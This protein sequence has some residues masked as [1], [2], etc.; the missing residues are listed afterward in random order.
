MR[1]AVLGATGHIGT[2]LVPRLVQRG[3][4]VIGISRGIRAPYRDSPEWA[5]VR[6][7]VLDRDALERAGSFGTTIAA[8]ASDAVID[9]ISFTVDSTAQVV[10]AL[11]DRVGQFLHCGTLWVHGVPFS[12]PYDE[13]APRKP[14]GEYGVRKAAIE[15]FL[16]EEATRGFPAT[17]LHPGH[18]TGPGWH[19]INPA[20]HL[21][22]RVFDR[23]ASGDVVT[24]PNDGSATLQHVHADDVAEAFALAVDHAPDSIGESFHIAACEP[25]SMR[26]YAEQAAQWFGRNAN[27]AFLP[28]EEFR[29]TLTPREAALT[30]DHMAH[31][32]HASIDKARRVL[33]FEPRFTAVEA[34]KDAVT[35]SR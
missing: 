4:D 11:R 6:Q 14:F 12:R 15:K 35:G 24:L 30:Y 16:L 33:G 29:T 23:L 21:D 8:L 20:G 5:D 26:S 32:P 25:V 31:S 7:V 13:T 1:I 2:W 27:L 28:W 10:D 19:P 17:V 18:I 3:H 22:P 9:L 34:V